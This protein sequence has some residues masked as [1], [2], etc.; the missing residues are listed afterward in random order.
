MKGKIF[1]IILMAA[2]VIFYSMSVQSQFGDIDN[3]AY[4]NQN[5]EILDSIEYT[6][7]NDYPD[8][9][10]GVMSLYN[11]LLRLQYLDGSTQEIITRS[12]MLMRELYVDQIV[13][14]NPLET[15]IANAVADSFTFQDIGNYMIGSSII[16]TNY[17][18]DGTATLLVQHVLIQQIVTKE[19][20]FID[21]NG[22]WQL[23]HWNDIDT[24]TGSY[25]LSEDEGM[26]AQA[27]S[28]SAE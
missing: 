13:D 12:V 15:Q 14:I 5:L 11:E 25:I 28:Q 24:S 21:V 10:A 2:V 17:V 19:Y 9:P 1:G 26:Q 7:F 23:Y 20:K 4:T 22:K 18:G 3:S 16:Q 6:I 8:S 27:Q